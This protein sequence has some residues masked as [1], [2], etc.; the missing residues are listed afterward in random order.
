[1]SHFVN[2]NMTPAEQ[3]EFVRTHRDLFERCRDHNHKVRMTRLRFCSNEGRYISGFDVD[4][5]QLLESLASK[6]VDPESKPSERG[7]SAAMTRLDP[8]ARPMLGQ[9][10]AAGVTTGRDPQPIS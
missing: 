5:G 9:R 6:V 4:A 1:M 3:V 8:P 7:V 2:E 10:Q